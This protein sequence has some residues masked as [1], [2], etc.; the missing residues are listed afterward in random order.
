MERRT[1]PID[2]RGAARWERDS[3]SGK[4]ARIIVTNLFVM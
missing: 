2:D 3:W 4:S 1:T